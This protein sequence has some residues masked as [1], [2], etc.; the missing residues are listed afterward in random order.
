MT[1]AGKRNGFALIV[2]LVLMALIATVVVAY[3]GNTQS[4]RSTSSG[5]ARRLHAK[6]VADGGLAAAVR[7][8]YDNT[9]TGNY[10]T[11]MPA[12]DPV[13]HRVEV[14][15]PSTSSDYLRIDN[16]VGDVL[17]S[18]V[19]TA[20][21]SAPT[22][23]ADPRPIPTPIPIP[24]PGG[25]LAIEDP[26]FSTTNSFDFNQVVRIGDSDTGR[27]VDPDGQPA[28][29][30]WVRVRNAL[31][32]LVGRYAFYIE[33]ES[34]K[35][36]INTVGNTQGGSSSHLRLNDMPVPPTPTPTAT[37]MSQLQ[38]LDPSALLNPGNAS[39]RGKAIS[40]L[41]QLGKPGERLASKS[42][43]A[44]LTEWKANYPEY[45]HAVTT[46]SKDDNTT[47]R[48]WVRMDLNKVVTDAEK[49]GTNA[50]KVEAA[51]KIANWIKDSWTGPQSITKLS[52]EQIFGDERLR[53]QVAANIVDYID[54]DRTPTDIAPDGISAGDDY[55]NV[56]VI[57][58]EKIP[59]LVTFMVVYQ[60]TGGSAAGAKLSMKLRF[61]FINLF[62]SP[63][64]LNESV[65]TIKVK[66]VPVIVKNNG[67]VF[68]RYSDT[69]TID[70]KDLRPVK[71]TG[72][73]VPAG[74]DGTSTS[75]VRTFESDFVVNEVP[76]P[77]P[78]GT[79]KPDFQS[80]LI[81]LSMFDKSG[82]RLDITAAETAEG[83]TGYKQGSNGSTGDFLDDS[84]T[85]ARQI[86]AI[87]VSEDKVPISRSFAD[88]RYRPRNL[89]E[90]WRR[91]NRT[92][93]DGPTNA[94]K[95]EE[96]TVAM[97]PRTY[98][99]DWTDHA[100]NRPLA[101]IRNEPMLNIGELGNIAMCEY[102]WRTG[103]LQH[104]ER[105]SNSSNAAAGADFV[106]RRSKAQDYVLLD[107]FRAGGDQTQSGA[108][109]INTQQ[110]L[111]APVAAPPTSA[112]R[113]LFLGVPIGAQTVA[114]LH[115]DRVA[116]D[117]N[118]TVVPGTVSSV[119]NRRN[120]V[121]VTPDADPKRPYFQRGELASTLS[122]LVATSTRVNGESRSTVTYS[123]LRNAP[124][125]VSESNP[126]YSRDL[127]VEQP[128]REVSNSITTRGNV[129][130]VLYI[131]QAIKDLNK[132][133]LANGP[134]EVFAE[135]LGE[136]FVERQGTFVP[137]GSVANAIK[138]TDSKM[139]V[140]WNRAITE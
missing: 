130:R 139:R 40:A 12:P 25:S 48:G 127:Q 100:G 29:G 73:T 92:D 118:T 54:A 22:P 131:G 125:V 87:Y 83:D 72:Y 24:E 99:V 49:T 28:F 34:M 21:L 55:E 74:V 50:A 14:Y 137:E 60:A 138:T 26:K 33:D 37:P 39:E 86:A 103:Y 5:Y 96:D 78:A 132:N 30:Q 115:A 23:Q 77:N 114:Q 101:F 104:P 102:P 19:D 4:N 16:A 128:F 13:P 123:A 43:V 42:S 7:L 47:A 15:S 61:N 52:Y 113:S 105:P 140:L 38:E 58:I 110:R 35:V 82:A 41:D 90:R 97:E 136:A 106:S 3:L 63:L 75:G 46:L 108:L 70:V 68:N 57:G 98:A 31:G 135:Y 81:E 134:Q 53:L 133:G 116:V 111:L 121:G 119:S 32:E 94:L 64:E 2:T 126:N 44:L 84:A 20:P 66:G 17:A 109:N 93:T 67:T 18:R 62:E 65:A 8:L 95:N 56:P 27:L 11:A 80:G 36:N 6:T 79:S 112:L 88:P 10:I 89:N 117:V 76:V 129:F 124:A 91:Q 71:G 85:A 51:K 122:R 9:K 1:R 107:L 45:A 59:Y 120:S 69:F